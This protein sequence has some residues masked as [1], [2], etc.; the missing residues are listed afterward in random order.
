MSNKTLK[1]KA[2]EWLKKKII[3]LEYPMGSPLYESDLC[4]ETGFGR[5]PVREAIQQLQ[6][7]GLVYVRPK[8]GT[9]VSSIDMFDFEKILESRIMLETHVIRRL[10]GA[11]PDAELKRFRSFFDEV[12][13]M[14][15]KLEIEGLL[16]V[17]RTFHEELVY[18]LGNQYLNTIADRIYDLVARTWYLSFKKRNRASLEAT[19]NDH[20]DILDALEKGDPETA[21]NVALKH[22]YDFR[23][24]VF[25]HTF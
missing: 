15:E 22:I 2:Y 14:I 10:A 3:T 8:K 5:T 19:L 7:E 11:M 9:F 24:K 13:V 4:K 17:E 16:K 1:S 6:A 18:L 12:P 25:D 23:R 20:L 21:E